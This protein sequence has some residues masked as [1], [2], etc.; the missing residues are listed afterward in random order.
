MLGKQGDP[1]L[2]ALIGTA[3]RAQLQ[4]LPG[5]QGFVAAP[6][7]SAE[8]IH[9]PLGSGQAQPL[10]FEHQLLSLELG[11]GLA[12]LYLTRGER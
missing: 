8:A 12:Q 2:F 4:L 6:V 7:A 9:L 5:W 1:L 10:L 11:Q 3:C